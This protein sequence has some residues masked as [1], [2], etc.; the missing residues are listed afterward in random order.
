MKEY[1]VVSGNT[2]AVV[3]WLGGVDEFTDFSE[4]QEYAE[5]VACGLGWDIS[6]DFLDVRD[7]W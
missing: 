7:N 5:E 4:A 2:G 6:E 3:L 1:C